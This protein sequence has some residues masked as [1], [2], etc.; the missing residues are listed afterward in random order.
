M[1]KVHK[2]F[3]CPYTCSL[4]LPF[5]WYV[6]VFGAL[7]WSFREVILQSNSSM[8]P[9]STDSLSTSSPSASVGRNTWSWVRAAPPAAATAGRSLQLGRQGFPTID[10]GSPW[11]KELGCRVREGRGSP[12]IISAVRTGLCEWRLTGLGFK[13]GWMAWEKWIK[14]GLLQLWACWWAWL[15][16]DGW[17]GRRTEEL[18]NGGGGGSRFC[19]TLGR[20]LP[21]NPLNRTWS[22]GERRDGSLRLRRQGTRE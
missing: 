17:Q 2:K 18:E 20:R 14:A 10:N 7:C 8:K 16:L 3:I 9:S 5:Q 19:K 22:F 11:G 15:V 21:E 12:C 1:K 13:L 6:D 4:F